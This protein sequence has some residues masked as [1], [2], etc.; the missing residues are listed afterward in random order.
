MSSS[1][2]IS[3]PK[4]A[5]LPVM[6][7]F[8]TIQGEG[9]HMGTAAYFIRIG[10]CDVGCVWCDVKES[11]DASAHQQKS[12]EGLTQRAKDSGAEIVVVTGGEPAMYDLTELTTLLQ[13]AGLRTH[14]ETSGAYALTGSW[15]WVCFSP[16][17][18]KSPIDAVCQ[19]A[20]ELKVIVYNKHDFKWAETHASK[21][22]KDCQHFLQPEWDKAAAMTP[23]IID[24]VKTNP[25]W[26][27]S[28]QTHKY[29]DI[30]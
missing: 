8:Y 19:E 29:M 17:K 3:T 24:Y 26:R 28:L 12:I 14:I 22:R 25:K 5:T 21:V 18:F 10:G 16:K 30:P 4:V 6:E 1:P 27:I 15:H 7:E 11:W 13:Q 20:D 23:L 9:A 2:E